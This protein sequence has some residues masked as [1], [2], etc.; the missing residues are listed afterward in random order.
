MSDEDN[1]IMDLENAEDL[2]REDPVNNGPTAQEQAAALFNQRLDLDSLPETLR[3]KSI[4][5]LIQRQVALEDAVRMSERAR[6]DL[7]RSIDMRGPTQP[8]QPAPTY[9][10]TLSKE[11]FAELMQTDPMAAVNYMIEQRGES[12][13]QHVEQR[14]APLGNAAAVNAERIARDKYAE[15]FELFGDQIQDL[16]KQT[17]NKAAFSNQQVWDDMISYI[18]GRPG[19]IEKYIE[20]RTKTQGASAREKEAAGA[21]VNLTSAS[22]PATMG[23]GS[24]SWDGADDVTREIALN[25]GFK[26]F[27]EYKKWQA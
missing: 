21:G 15:E 19:N 14:I 11:E 13:I 23:G 20:R 17:A 24:A 7:V 2:L 18:R 10:P 4:G 12:F 3:G 9:A 8:A 5:E 25:L 22:R 6:E 27:A 26:S 16:Y 1:N